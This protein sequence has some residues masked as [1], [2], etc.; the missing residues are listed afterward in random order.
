MRHSDETTDVKV[1]PFDAIITVVVVYSGP[2]MNAYHW[3]IHDC[4]ET[5]EEL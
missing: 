3:D 4:R 1:I 5:D 2:G